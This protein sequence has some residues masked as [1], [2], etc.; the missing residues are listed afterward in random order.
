MSELANETLSK[1]YKHAKHEI[2]PT[3]AKK[4]VESPTPAKIT[5]GGIIKVPELNIIFIK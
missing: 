1:M 4:T 2:N 3:N 5:T